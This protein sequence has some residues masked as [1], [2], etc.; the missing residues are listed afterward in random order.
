M[1]CTFTLGLQNVY[2]S[3]F[4][5]L[6]PV[7]LDTFLQSCQLED[8]AMIV[9]DMATE[10]FDTLNFSQHIIADLKSGITFNVL[11]SQEKPFR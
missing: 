11:F 7:L 1:L 8:S 3:C 4:S 2:K 5:W 10:V 6:S 9:H